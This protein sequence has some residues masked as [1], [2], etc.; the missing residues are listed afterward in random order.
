VI[1]DSAGSGFDDYGGE[2]EL[3]RVDFSDAKSSDSVLIGKARAKCVYFTNSFLLD[4]QA[5][6]FCYIITEVRDSRQ[7]PG[8]R[9]QQE[10]RNTR[11]V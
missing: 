1:K 9:W 10:L 3:H 2:L 11:M 5:N 8:Q 4:R 7:L 6:F